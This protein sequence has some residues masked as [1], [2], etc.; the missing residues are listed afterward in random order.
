MFERGNDN[1]SVLALVVSGAGE[2]GEFG[3]GCRMKDLDEATVRHLTLLAAILVTPGNMSIA[4]AWRHAVD[5][6]NF[7]PFWGLELEDD[8]GRRI[9]RRDGNGD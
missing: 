5:I 9:V 3:G 4:Q 2:C 6:V 1:G 7:A 8:G